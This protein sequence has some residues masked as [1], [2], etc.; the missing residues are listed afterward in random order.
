MK[1]IRQIIEESGSITIAQFME[2]AMYDAKYGYYINNNPIGKDADF[3]TAPEISQLFGE[4]IGVYCLDT[5]IKLG[6]PL[7]FNLVELGAGRGTL[8]TDVLR[9]TKHVK[10][11]HEAINIHLVETNNYL[12]GVQK[13]ALKHHNVIWHQDVYTIPNNV[14]LI[15]VANEFFDC[16]PI[17][18][19]VRNYN[20][21]QEFSVSIMP[22]SEEFFLMKTPIMSHF[23]ESLTKEYPKSKYG[24]ILEICYPA[25]TIMQHLASILNKAQGSFLIIDY[26]YYYN[27]LER[28]YFNGTLQGVKNHKFNPIFSDIGRADLTAHVDFYALKECALANFCHVQEVVNQREFLLKMGIEFRAQQLL[29][30]AKSPEEEYE[31]TSGLSRLINLEQMGNLF[32]VMDVQSK[33]FGPRLLPDQKR[34]AD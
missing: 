15:I 33:S 32:K 2:L 19:Y 3:I 7:K 6:K 31:I 23:S 13:E 8:M 5:W 16:L 12:R 30:K 14:P 29:A 27:P 26:G 21:W 20:G 10:G 9:A 22:K 17:N 25:V 11:F 28:V 4:M 18:Q 34:Q 24:S 1:H